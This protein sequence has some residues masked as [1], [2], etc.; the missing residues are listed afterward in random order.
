M[1]KR[2]QLRKRLCAMLMASVVLVSTFASV[3]VYDTTS[4]AADYTPTITA[5]PSGGETVSLL[6]GGIFDFVTNYKPGTAESY[7]TKGDCYA[8]APATIRWSGAEDALYYTVKLSTNPDL[9]DA[10]YYLS[11]DSSLEVEDLHS[12]EQYYYQIIA[13]YAEKT[14]KSRI[15]GFKTAQLPRT[16]TIDAVTNTRDLGGYYTI[17]GT[18]KVKEGIVYRGAN[19]DTISEQGKIDFLEKYGIKTDLD[20]RGDGSRTESPLGSAVNFLYLKGPTYSQIWD[21]GYQDALAQEIKTFADESNYPIY[22][23]CQIGRDR[24][25]TLAFLINGLLGVSEQDLRMEYE[26][27]MFSPSGWSG[28]DETPEIYQVL[29]NDQF[30]PLVNAM[31]AYADGTLAENI[32]Q[33]MLDIGVTSQ[34]IAKIKSILLEDVSIPKSDETGIVS[35]TKPGETVE[36]DEFKTEYSKNEAPKLPKEF[37]CDYKAQTAGTGNVVY[38]ATK[39]EKLTSEQAADKGV[40]TGY[41]DNVLVVKNAGNCIGLSLDFSA[42]K[43]PTKLVKKITFRVYVADDG[44]ASD[45]YPQIRIPNPTKTNEWI[46]RYAAFTKTNSWVDISLENDGMNFERGNFAD[47]SKDGY[48]DQFELCARNAA[49]TPLYIDKIT[50]TLNK[51]DEVAPTLIY[52]GETNR[53]FA[54]GTTFSFD[55]TAYD[56]FEEREIAV[57]YDWNK[58]PFENDGKTLK[59]GSYSLH[60][61]AED[62]YGNAVKEGPINVV[63]EEPDSQNPTI[64]LNTDTVYAVAGTKAVQNVKVSDNSG[65]VQKTEYSWT[66]G[67][68]TNIG[69]LKNGSHTMTVKATDNYSNQSQKNVTVI[70]SDQEYVNGVV[71]DEQSLASNFTAPVLSGVS[72]GVMYYTT[73]AVSV[74]DTD[75]ASVA[76]NGK[77]VSDINELV[78][79]KGNTDAQYTVV[80]TDLLGNSSTITVTMKPLSAVMEPLDGL[81]VSNVTEENREVLNQVLDQIEGLLNEKHATKEEKAELQKMQKQVQRLLGAIGKN[82]AALSPVMGD[83]VRVMPIVLLMMA[84]LAV[85]VVV[86]RRKKKEQN[87]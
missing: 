16:I 59:K 76:V 37:V 8:P 73:Q 63:V 74:R 50:V 6:N 45:V 31:K 49:E 67:A 38:G 43:I 70:V 1:K 34:E 52:N 47:L 68:L 26:L 60:I 27:S 66:D 39:V 15:F 35:A 61:S 44:N 81:T 56:E 65:R 36:A 58:S 51:D 42:L 53:Y 75:L 80:A 5:S 10:V 28:Y 86:L 48:L 29:L 3:I 32:E 84:A 78:M 87:G 11:F 4:K 71:V 79:L 54:V 62:Y 18:K 23:H 40:P 17:D 21:T 57:Q 83:V 55:A 12:A 85:G 24:T 25:G 30:G 14:V 7:C 77:A 13:E 64:G 46:M 72:E 33:Y 20:V 82:L 69:A 9:T 2:E 19:L 22:F 41:S